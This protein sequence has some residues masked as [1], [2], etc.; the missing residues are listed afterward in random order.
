MSEDKTSSTETDQSKAS[1]TRQEL[2]ALLERVNQQSGIL[3]KITKALEKLTEPKASTAKIDDNINQ[4]VEAR[5]KLLE[6]REKK[7]LEK[8]SST[9]MRIIQT[10]LARALVDAGVQP[11]MAEDLSRV[12]LQR[13]SAKFQMD[14]ETE[15]VLVNTSGDEKINLQR[16]SQLYLM[17]DK[18]KPYL[19]SKKNPNIPLP[20]KGDSSTPT[21]TP[22]Q[23]FKN[24]ELRSQW[25][26]ADPEGYN[27]ATEQ[28]HSPEAV[29]E[30]ARAKHKDS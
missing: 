7:S 2:E 22:E 24:S 9:R 12:V 10:K 4:G 20:K 13:E 16:F 18:G 1:V 19:G 25:K 8:E 17:S 23:A 26:E 3:G 5:L 28:H 21:L 15:D 30:R 11:T 6:E 27:Q 14:D 29:L